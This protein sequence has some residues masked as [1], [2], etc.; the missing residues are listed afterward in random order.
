MS[1]SVK[2]SRLQSELESL[3]YPI[4]VTAAAESF[5]DTTVTFADGDA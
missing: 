5:A 2:L 4:D 3:S 1:Q